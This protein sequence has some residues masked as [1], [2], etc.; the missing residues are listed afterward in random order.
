MPRWFVLGGLYWALAGMALWGVGMGAQ[1]SIVKA[2]IA[3]LPPKNKLGFAY[4][5]FN[6]CHGLF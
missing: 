1:E 5:L 2:A 6:T 3:E 4:G